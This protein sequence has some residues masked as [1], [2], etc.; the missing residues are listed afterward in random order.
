MVSR[1]K[2]NT[3]KTKDVGGTTVEKLSKDYDLP[4]SSVLSE[5]KKINIKKKSKADIVEKADLEKVL[6]HFAA[7]KSGN[8][9]QV[10]SDESSEIHLKSPV[11]VKNLAEALGKKPPELIKKLMM[12]NI[13]AS[14]NQVIDVNVAK[15]LCAEFGFELLLDKREKKTQKQT[16]KQVEIEEEL[17]VDNPEDI[18][19]RPPV[20]TFLG[21]VDHG[22]TSIQ[23]AIRK[24]NIVKGEAGGITQHIGAS[25]VE[26]GGKK[27][28][29]IDTPG[30]EAFTQMRARG[31]NV[32]D[33]AI[34][35]VAADDG[36]MP[37][38]IEAMN[39]AKA[40]GVPIIVAINKIDLPAA[41]PEKVLLHMQQNELMSEDW[42]GEVGTVKVSAMTGEGLDELLERILLESEMLEL[43]ANPTRQADC[44]V[45]ESELE[46]GM[47]ATAN[48][49][50][51]NGSLKL[52]DCILSGQYY[53]KVK[54]LI[55]YHGK[56]VKKVGPSMPVKVLGLSGVPEAGARLV[57]CKNEKEAAE[58]A[59]RRKDEKREEDLSHNQASSLEDLFSTMEENKKDE[60]TL[61]V[62]TDV[63]GTAEAIKDSLAKIPSEK[64]KITIV[65]SA[66]GAIADSDILLAA[67]SKAIV[68]GFHVKV[69]PGV[70]EMAKREGVE[71]R[72]Y[73]II[74]ELLEDIEDALVGRLA[75]EERE[76]EL[77]KAVILKIFSMTKGPKVC[78]CRV[79]HGTIRAGAKA[80]VFRNNELIFNGNLDS[81]KHFQD[82]VKELKAGQ[83]C[84]IKLDN[85]LDFQEGDLIQ[86]YEVE[87]KKATLK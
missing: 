20:V 74:Y 26:R 45:L 10:S 33:I 14:I 84:G 78:G 37:Q 58:I 36:F 16:E 48:I 25:V 27:I 66:V 28:V 11:I 52:S 85:F 6:E 59:N 55:D 7:M 75:P 8:E 65:H 13:L 60:L 3:K 64:I 9:E 47:G 79:E 61:I 62:K 73:S 70:N 22:K 38:T 32:T 86:V 72:L 2:E 19:N 50:V 44:I 18:V 67:A 35:V 43:N 29:F 30:H 40:A 1:K 80:R 42:G 63:Q 77:G 82:T 41:N 83:E 15:E 81:L 34:L 57:G 23:D 76:K 21:H 69:N 24:T 12:K 4:V 39:H 49:L 54:A 51:R 46:T 53:G 31:A 87:L 68:V 56:R 5:L 17:F 71:I